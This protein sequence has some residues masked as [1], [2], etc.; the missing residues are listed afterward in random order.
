MQK[1]NSASIR[2]EFGGNNTWN[3]T[4][5]AH[6]ELLKKHGIDEGVGKKVSFVI[7]LFNC[8]D[9]AALRE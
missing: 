1:T 6:H 3:K 5:R 8:R 9:M 2:N 4:M 7:L